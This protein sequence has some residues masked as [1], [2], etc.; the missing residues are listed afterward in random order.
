[1][2]N[3]I[4]VHGSMRDRWRTKGAV[5]K[6]STDWSLREKYRCALL[7]KRV[8]FRQ[9]R[10]KASTIPKNTPSA[11]VANVV[12]QAVPW[13]TKLLRQTTSKR[14]RLR[15][16]H[17]RSHRS[18]RSPSGRS[19]FVMPLC[20]FTWTQPFPFC[21]HTEHRRHAGRATALHRVAVRP[22]TH[23]E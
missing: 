3:L 10:V 15:A 1:M 20:Q 9:N 18:H 21:Q 7:S 11:R 19:Y 4:R 5:H 17:H 14:Q 13:V 8:L 22:V 12:L 2:S 23:V 16:S 6:T